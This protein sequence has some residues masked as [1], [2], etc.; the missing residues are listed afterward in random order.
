M[1]TGRAKGE[2]EREGGEKKEKKNFHVSKKIFFLIFFLIF[3]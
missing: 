1:E 3:F 2:R